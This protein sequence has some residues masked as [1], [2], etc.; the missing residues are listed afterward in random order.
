MKILLLLLML[1]CCALPVF[2]AGQ[3]QIKLKNGKTINGVVLF[4]NAGQ[5]DFDSDD[6]GLLVINS[7]DIEVIH[8]APRPASPKISPSPAS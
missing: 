5:L 4:W 6:E 2:A 1:F 7:S 8:L 3:D